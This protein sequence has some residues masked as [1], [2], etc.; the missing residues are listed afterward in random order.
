VFLP[1]PSKF[2]E[3]LNVKDKKISIGNNLFKKKVLA[4]TFKKKL[5]WD[6]A[7]SNSR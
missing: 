4:I 5:T 6:V 1:K 2:V 3:R 7:P